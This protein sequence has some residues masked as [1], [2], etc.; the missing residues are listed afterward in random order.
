MKRKKKLMQEPF[1][2]YCP[3]NIV[4][5]FFFFLYY[6]VPIVLQLKGLEG[7]ASLRVF[8]LQYKLYCRLV[9]AGCITIQ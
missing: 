9:K 3:N 8:V 6:K 2:G 1:L 5:N 4:R 7:L